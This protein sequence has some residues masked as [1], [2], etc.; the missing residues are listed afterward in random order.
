MNHKLE[1]AGFFILNVNNS[2][3]RLEYVRIL[4]Y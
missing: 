3:M 1:M 4:V 2:G